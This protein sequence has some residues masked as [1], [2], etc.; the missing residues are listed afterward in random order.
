[1]RQY[2]PLPA[3]VSPSLSLSG[4]RLIL[5][6][7]RSLPLLSD[8][9]LAKKV[10]CSPSPQNFSVLVA[11]A[12]P[13]RGAG[14]DLP[15]SSCGGGRRGWF[16]AKPFVRRDHQSVTKNNGLSYTICSDSFFFPIFSYVPFCPG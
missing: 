16:D 6:L 7:P 4:H 14:A 13:D 2:L 3:F 12:V 15:C 9:S 8:C 1:E 10:S 11:P 5:P